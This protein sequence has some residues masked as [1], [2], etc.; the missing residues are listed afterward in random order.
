MELLEEGDEG[1]NGL[2]SRL[3]CFNKPKKVHGSLIVSFY[4]ELKEFTPG[5][6]N[7]QF[8]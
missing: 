1:C 4:S 5:R 7:L 8:Y 3:L 2:S 6:Q